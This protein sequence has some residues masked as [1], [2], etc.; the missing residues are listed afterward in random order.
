MKLINTSR[1]RPAVLEETC[2]EPVSGR[3]VALPPHRG[4]RCKA[5][6]FFQSSQQLKKLFLIINDDF[7]NSYRLGLLACLEGTLDKPFGGVAEKCE[8]PGL[9][10]TARISVIFF[11]K[12][13][14]VTDG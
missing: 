4:T 1:T 5:P 10:S 13:L 9:S 12:D 11:P 14:I 2:A 8:I 6:S 7:L 3:L